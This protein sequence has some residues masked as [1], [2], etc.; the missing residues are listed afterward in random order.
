MSAENQPTIEDLEVARTKLKEVLE[1][2]DNY[3]GNNPDKYKAAIADAKVLVHDLETKL[4][5][6]GVLELT[7]E[8]KLFKVLDRQFPNAG[9][10]D[11]VEYDGRKFQRRFTPVATSVSGKTVRAWRPYWVEVPA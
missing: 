5:A 3:D 1:R 2:W 8:E 9:S 4:K 10:R 11:V 6:A 7:E